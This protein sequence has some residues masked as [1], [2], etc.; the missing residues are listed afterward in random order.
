[1]DKLSFKKAVKFDGYLRSAFI[2]AIVT[3]LVG[4]VL[5]FSRPEDQT[6]LIFGSI[7]L[8]AVFIF[9]IRYILLTTQVVDC[10][11]VQGTITRAFYYRGAKRLTYTYIVDGATYKGKAFINITNASRGLEK[12]E[13]VDLLVKNNNPKSSLIAEFYVATGN[14]LEN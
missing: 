8:V 3:I 10:R 9:A 1:M 6:Y 2:S 5:Y 14:H 11:E 13:T 7:A 4:I 12:D